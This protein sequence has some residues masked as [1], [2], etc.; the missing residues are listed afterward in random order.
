MGEDCKKTQDRMRK[1]RAKTRMRRFNLAKSRVRAGAT[2]LDKAVY[3]AGRF[4]ANEDPVPVSAQ[5]GSQRLIFVREKK[6]GYL[7]F[8]LK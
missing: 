6:S 7:F 5:I 2:R 4:R 1:T 8:Q 3:H